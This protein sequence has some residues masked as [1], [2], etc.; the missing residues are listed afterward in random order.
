MQKCEL[1]VTGMS[2]SACSARVEKVVNGLEGV[3][4]ASV[5]LLKNTLTLN[6]DESVLG[7]TDVK[8][9]V[10]EA[11]YGLVLPEAAESG[12][13]VTRKAAAPETGDEALA[14]ER[15][16]LLWAFAFLI[17]LCTISMGPML[18]IS[19][20]SFLSG[21]RGATSNALA[22][23]LLLVPILFLRRVT[24]I[25]G[26]KASCAHHGRACGDRRRRECGLRRLV[27]LYDESLAGRRRYGR[28]YALLAR[29]VF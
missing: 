6:Y 27:A 9:A 12:K 5:N 1:N 22:Q 11:G 20:P 29:P 15:R 4:T 19:L 16:N 18:G 23:L 26:F 17:V 2:C 25:R 21:T 7:L 8:K 3:D 28:L 13:K 10:E 24:F 14:A